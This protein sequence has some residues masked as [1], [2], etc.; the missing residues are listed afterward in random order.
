MALATGTPPLVANIGG[1]AELIEDSQTGFIFA[2]GD[3][4][5]FATKLQLALDTSL[6]QFHSMQHN[7][8]EKAQELTLDAYLSKLLDLMK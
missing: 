1:A 3:E 7:C 4:R 8:H 6:E 2:P 5:S